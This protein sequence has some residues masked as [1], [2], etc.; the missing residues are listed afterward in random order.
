MIL[1]D[2]LKSLFS[3]ASVMRARSA[4]L[5]SLLWLL[6][7]LLPSLLVSAIFAGPD[8]FLTYS[9]IV[10]VSFSVAAIFVAYFYF[11]IKDP[12]RLQTERFMITQR[13]LNIL[14]MKGADPIPIDYRN[15]AGTSTIDIKPEPEGK[16]GEIE[17]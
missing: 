10:L 14:E 8:T 7:I 5:T 1:D 6:A 16:G 11:M 15:E 13:K 3:R 4:A 12:D 2:F 17:P 9:L